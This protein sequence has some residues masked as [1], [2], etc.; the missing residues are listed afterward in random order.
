MWPY[1][2]QK[3]VSVRRP[4]VNM[5]MGRKMVTLAW[6][7]LI[8]TSLDLH[9]ETSEVYLRGILPVTGSAEL[10]AFHRALAPL[11]INLPG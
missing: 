5:Y 9:E 11:Y 6:G 10:R 3:G 1:F 4:I 2:Y 7:N 8:K